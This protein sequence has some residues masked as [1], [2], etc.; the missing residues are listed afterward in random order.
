MRLLRRSTTGFLV[1]REALLFERACCLVRA[2]CA[3]FAYFALC[4]GWVFGCCLALDAGFAPPFIPLMRLSV[5][6]YEL[7]ELEEARLRGFPALSELVLNSKTFCI[8][9]SPHLILNSLTNIKPA[10]S[11]VSIM[12]CGNNLSLTT[13]VIK[14]RRFGIFSKVA[15]YA[16]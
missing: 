3:V 9:V 7:A 14:A 13:H 11:K 6:P 16:L 5:P 4:L 2:Y 10:R 15:T 12:P 8:V 1:L